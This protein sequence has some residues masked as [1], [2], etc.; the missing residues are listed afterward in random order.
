MEFRISKQDLLAAIGRVS[1]ALDD[2]KVIPIYAD[3]LIDVFDN[4]IRLSTN[5]V[6]MQMKTFH[7]LESVGGASFGVNG[8]LFIDLIKN[9]PEGLITFTISETNTLR[10]SIGRKKLNLNIKSADDFPLAPKYENMTFTPMPGFMDD[11]NAVMYAVKTTEDARVDITCVYVNGQEFAATDMQRLSVRAHSHPINGEFLI[12]GKQLAK[13]SKV[14][15]P[16]VE[17][18]LDID[19]NYI[20]IKKD[21]TV[22]SLRTVARNFINYKTVIPTGGHDVAVFNKRDLLEALKMLSTVNDKLH[23]AILDFKSD[24]LKV[25]KRDRDIGDMEDTITISFTSEVALGVN[26]EIMTDMLNHIDSD[27]VN[28]EIYGSLRPLKVQEGRNIHVLAP[29]K[30]HLGD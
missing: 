7:P 25:M 10:V 8:K 16:D 6:E 30:Y 17:V 29:I 3:I 26:L 28:L 2:G 27:T 19:S 13:V 5:C 9:L 1:P 20:H 12:P 21:L 15:G 18:F 14:F 22:C 23:L 24:S 4:G 11:A